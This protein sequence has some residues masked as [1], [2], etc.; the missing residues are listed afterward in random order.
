MPFAVPI[1]PC[2]LRTQ[3]RLLYPQLPVDCLVS[4]GCGAEPPTERSK[5][6]SAVSCTCTHNA[7][8]SLLHVLLLL[9]LLL[10][11]SFAVAAAEPSKRTCTASHLIDAASKLIALCMH[12]RPLN[13]CWTRVQCCWSLPA[14]W[15]ACTR[16]SPQRCPWFLAP[17][18]IG[19]HTVSTSTVTAACAP[20]LRRQ[21]ILRDCCS[22]AWRAG[23]RHVAR[24]WSRAC[25][26][27]NVRVRGRAFSA[28]RVQS[29]KV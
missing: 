10:P 7:L 20:L 3:A 5:G 29:S 4:L 25:V 11:S 1:P 8:P 26:R 24:G 12:A 28:A 2:C 14:P 18:T 16:R 23:G 9:P 21:F 13:R 6:L 27:A 15:T 22:V 17:N 19:E